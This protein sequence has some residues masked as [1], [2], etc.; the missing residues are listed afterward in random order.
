MW[1]SVALMCGV[2]IMVCGMACVAIMWPVLIFVM[3]VCWRPVLLTMLIL[4]DQRT[5][6]YG[7]C[8]ACV[9]GCVWRWLAAAGY[10]VLNWQRHVYVYSLFNVFNIFSQCVFLFVCV[11]CHVCVLCGNV[12]LLVC[13]CVCVGGNVMA[14]NVACMWLMLAGGMALAWPVAVAVA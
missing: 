2:C 1:R 14:F 4:T 13:V 12:V 11:S 6:V 9:Y 5:A 3:C 7:V 8:V 10:G